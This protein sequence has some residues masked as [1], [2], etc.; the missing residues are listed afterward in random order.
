M[1]PGNKRKTEHI[2]TS[3]VVAVEQTMS[4]AMIEPA[5]KR[6]FILEDITVAIKAESAEADV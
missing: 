2:E 5:Q 6:S 4:D 1:L 3:S